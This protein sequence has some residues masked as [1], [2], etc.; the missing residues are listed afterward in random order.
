MTGTPATGRALVVGDGSARYVLPGLRSLARAGWQ[1]GVAQ[2][3]PG[4]ATSSRH[5]ARVHRLPR[6]EH[7][8]GAWVDA[9]AALVRDGGYDVVFPADDIELLALSAARER[10]AAVVPYAS[11]DVVLAAVDKLTVTR[12]AE[13]AGLGVPHTTAVDDAAI[14]AVAGPVVVKARLHWSPAA[15]PGGRHLPV[16]VVDTPA[17]ASAAVDVV[18]SGGGEPVLQE[19]VDGTLLA[20]SLVLDGAGRVRACSQQETQRLTL[21]RTSARAR[22]VEVDE[23]LLGRA[24]DLL[25]SLGWTGLANLQ[26]LR[27]ADGV[28]RLIDLN[29]RWYGSL[30]LA[31]AAGADLPRVWADLAVGRDPGP[32]QRARAGVRFQSLEEDVRVARREGPRAVAAALAHAARATHSTWDRSDPLPAARAVAARA[33]R[34]ARRAA[35]R[36]SP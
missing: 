4:L 36:S 7:G 16:Q 12:A 34:L 11:H 9:V 24:A 31:V 5:C 26:L 1:V 8:V 6:V 2:P 13:Q 25:R 17:A 27:P 19:V 10:V 23:A 22:T 32:V 20:L 21:R 28:P 15:G 33:A 29:G 18:R 35:A 14:A 3:E 30:A